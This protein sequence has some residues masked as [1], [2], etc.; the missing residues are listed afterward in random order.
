[1]KV[2]VEFMIVEFYGH[3]MVGIL[4]NSPNKAGQ[5]QGWMTISLAS[6]CQA[7]VSHRYF[8]LPR[9]GVLPG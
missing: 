5:I 7:R 6:V 1:M 2:T 4:I 8:R 3:C 9:Q